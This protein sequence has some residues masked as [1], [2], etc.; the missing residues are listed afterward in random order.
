MEAVQSR[1]RHMSRV[2]PQPDFDSFVGA[3]RFGGTA[4]F[5]LGKTFTAALPLA[6]LE[7]A[8]DLLAVAGL[9]EGDVLLACF[10]ILF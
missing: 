8:T 5:L 6:A 1:I 7:I 3:L 4:V 2:F 9:G 10:G